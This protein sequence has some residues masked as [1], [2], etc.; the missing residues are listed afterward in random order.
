MELYP[1]YALPTQATCTKC[2]EFQTEKYSVC[3]TFRALTL[4]SC[5][6]LRK[7]RDCSCLW[8]ET[9]TNGAKVI[10]LRSL[11]WLETDQWVWSTER[12]A[13][14]RR[15]I[16]LYVYGAVSRREGPPNFTCPP[17]PHRRIHAVLGHV[18]QRHASRDVIQNGQLCAS[19]STA[20][21]SAQGTRA[22]PVAD[23]HLHSGA[24]RANSRHRGLASWY[25]NRARSHE[26]QNWTPAWDKIFRRRN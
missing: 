10:V 21:R 24:L 25:S 2:T 1:Q 11:M 22:H 19:A 8:A 20:R 14:S 23:S 16:W 18:Q 6:H 26:L 13:S 17:H 7:T 9:N 3:A 12:L 15:R 5:A 4:C